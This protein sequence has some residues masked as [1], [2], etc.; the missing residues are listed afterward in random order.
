MKIYPINSDQP[1]NTTSPFVVEPLQVVRTMFYD[2]PD[3]Y[4]WVLEQYTT[5]G[6]HCGE[7]AIWHNATDCCGS[8][9]PE[10]G[11]NQFDVGVPGT[12]R[13]VAIRCDG[14]DAEEIDL[15]GTLIVT[16][17]IPDPN[18]TLAA[19]ILSENQMAACP[20]TV[21]VTETADQIILSVDGTAYPIP[22]YTDCAGTAL[23]P[24]DSMASCGDL[25]GAIAGVN[26]AV[27]TTGPITGDGV[28]VP[29]GIDFS[30]MNATDIPAV[31]PTGNGGTTTQDALDNLQLSIAGITSDDDI[32]SVAI[33]AT[34]TGIQVAVTESGTPVTGEIS[35]GDL[36]T[37]LTG[38]AAFMQSL[39]LALIDPTVAPINELAIGP[40]SLLY[41]NS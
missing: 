37:A 20:I 7:E 39:A 16:R 25:S 34:A 1:F 18:G 3:G 21:S 22:K 33:S 15:E 29:V 9:G 12:Y 8:E 23:S 14:L 30:Q 32:S 26:T 2:A 27:S 31:D 40:A 17:D 4:R 36:A 28:A 6:E 41:V 38:D 24:G 5:N 13:F 35:F 11:A 19:S 10:V